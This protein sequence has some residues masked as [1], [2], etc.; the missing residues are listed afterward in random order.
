MD[1]NRTLIPSAGKR[2]IVLRKIISNSVTKS[3]EQISWPIVNAEKRRDF[4]SLERLVSPLQREFDNKVSF[5]AVE[6][7]DGQKVEIVLLAKFEHPELPIQSDIAQETL[8]ALYQ[9]AEILKDIA[10][11]PLPPE[12]I[13]IS[14][15]DP[16]DSTATEVRA[17]AKYSAIANLYRKHLPESGFSLGQETESQFVFPHRGCTMPLTD[18]EE[19]IFT[20]EIRR[21]C[22][23]TRT[24]MIQS[25]NNKCTELKLPYS[26]ETR[27]RFLDAQLHQKTV[28]ML[29]SPTYRMI[30]GIRKLN[31]GTIV[32]FIQTIDGPHQASFPI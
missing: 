24:I 29:V 22:D 6:Q 27:A 2:V 7:T 8:K 15:G 20:G 30:N 18:T 10:E 19:L 31:G 28:R 17:P 14:A 13:S 4:Q 23:Q 11:S 5:E 26:S 12:L 9:A 16:A 21:V 25:D 32:K 1:D 3:E